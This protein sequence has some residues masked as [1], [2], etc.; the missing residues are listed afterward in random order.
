MKSKHFRKYLILFFFITLLFCFQET[1]LV[2]AQTEELIVIIDRPG[3]GEH[4]YASPKTLLYS[5]PIAGRVA[6][7]EFSYHEISL[8]LEIYQDDEIVIET[9]L[10]LD[11]DNLFS[12]H[13]TVNPESTFDPFAP[14]HGVNCDACHH[15][16]TIN[17]VPG[18]LKIRVIAQDPKGQEAI[19]ERNIVVDLSSYTTIPVQI[20]MVGDTQSPIQGIPITASTR[21]YM[22][23]T[24]HSTGLADEKGFAD[25]K[26]EALSE[27]KTYYFLKVEPVEINGVMYESVEPVEVILSPQTYQSAPI[28]IQVMTHLG[29]V[30]G[31]LV[32]IGYLPEKVWAID[33]NSGAVYE[34]TIADEGGFK[35]T[36]LPFSEY[37]ITLECESLQTRNQS[38]NQET[39]HL[40]NTDPIQLTLS[41][42]PAEYQ[43]FQFEFYSEDGL[44]LPF[45]WVEVQKQ[46]L[47]VATKPDSGVATLY[48]PPS[49]N[50]VNMSFFSPGSQLQ[51]QEI[52][53][54]EMGS[55]MEVQL[56]S[57]L[58]LTCT[59]WGEGEVFLPSQT[60]ASLIGDRIQFVSGWIW[61][62][63]KRGSPL[64]I[65]TPEGEISLDGGW[66]ALEKFPDQSSWFFLMEGEAK[67]NLN[68]GRTWSVH[69]GEMLSLGKDNVHGPVPMDDLAM[70][71]IRPD[72]LSLNL[73]ILMESETPP[74]TRITIS[75][76]I[77]LITLIMILG[78]ILL[79]FYPWIRRVQSWV[80][81]ALGFRKSGEN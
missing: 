50:P 6:S 59:S 79:L 42:E 45:V 73:Q 13:A 30:E 3:E 31:H 38:C 71:A 1:N 28:T 7:A 23:R 62:Q 33:K 26:V 56:E 35:F 67:V 34:T 15:G 22:W 12:I 4:L 64:I 47:F 60:S 68:D 66:F 11:S 9:P 41:I 65:E 55:T 74:S 2:A 40:V 18:H 53:P 17:L 32:V 75:Q 5:I 10:N 51:T 44:P 77:R 76:V 29:E 24:R 21:L 36:N 58:D 8:K 52:S 19:A 43:R 49:N 80:M 14:L 16:G 70:A 48:L 81:I 57:A 72:R 61:G 78:F 27:A 69:D 37:M 25:I 20:E 54:S 39:V 46:E 63:D